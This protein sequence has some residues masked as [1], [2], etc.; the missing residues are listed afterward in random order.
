MKFKLLGL[1]IF[2]GCSGANAEEYFRSID[3]LGKVHYG[4]TPLANAAEVEKLRA[5]SNPQLNNTLPFETKRAV[6]KFPVTLYSAENCGNGCIMA[7]DLFNQRGVPY[8]EKILVTSDEI[9]AFKK[10][11]GSDGLPTI[12]IGTLWLKGFLAQQWHTELNKAG[13]PK[14]AP[15]GI[16]PANTSSKIQNEK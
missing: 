14:S 2:L 8:T 13:Y 1:L 5:Q 16:P 10:V 9:A 12:S 7:R 3:Q 4:D 11:S 6:E 15:Y